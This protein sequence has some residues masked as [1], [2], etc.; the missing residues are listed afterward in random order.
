MIEICVV[1]KRTLPRIR[2]VRFDFASRQ[3]SINAGVGNLKSL[4]ELPSIQKHPALEENPDAL[5]G[6]PPGRLPG[7]SGFIL[8][9]VRGISISRKF[10]FQEFPADGNSVQRR[11]PWWGVS[12]WGGM[13]DLCIQRLDL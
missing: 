2:C 1:E 10:L 9:A 12:A 4:R 7:A 5:P 11:M 3:R 8:L 13:S 6:R